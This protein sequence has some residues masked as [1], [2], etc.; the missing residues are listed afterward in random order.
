M[1]STDLFVVDGSEIP[2][3]IWPGYSGV[4]EDMPLQFF[5]I[6]NSP[7]PFNPSTTLSFTLPQSGKA[8]LAVYSITGQKIRTLLNGPISAGAHS[9]T[10]DGRDDSG[11]L[12]SSGVYLSRLTSGTRIATGKM[13]LMK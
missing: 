13:L 7:N 11:K 12:V 4:N 10:W 3:S 5:L 1:F 6:R 9:V 8:E 2:K